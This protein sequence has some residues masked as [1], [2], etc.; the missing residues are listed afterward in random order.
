MNDK[1]IL[2]TGAAGFIGRHTIGPLLADGYTVHAI[3]RVPRELRDG[4]LWHQAD[5]LDANDRARVLESV[6]PQVLLH[7]A[8]VTEHGKFW[9][10]PDNALW[11]EASID[12]FTS[13]AS[14]DVRRI[15]GVGSCAEYDWN[16]ADRSPWKES[17]PCQ[18]HTPYGKAKLATL[19]ALES[20]GVEFAWGRIFHLFGVG[21]HPARLIPSIIHALA[22]N[23]QA[24]CTSGRQTRDFMDVRDVG[25]AL[26]ALVASGATGA[27][28]IA[29]GTAITIAEIAILIGELMQKPELISLG[30]L[31]DRP[32]DPP[33]MVAD[34]RK[35]LNEVQFPGGHRLED[36]LRPMIDEILAG[37]RPPTG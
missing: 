4:V 33:Y 12:L 7:L 2:V 1:T 17:D 19:G 37:T 9:T 20:L 3:A 8:W 28:N 15:V 10:S 36:G 22:E 21:E 16:R 35:L 34:T 24:R 30:A 14:A 13:A 26:A 18:P 31:P 6:N 11:L 32:D 29:S 25:A 27:V 23:R 5:L